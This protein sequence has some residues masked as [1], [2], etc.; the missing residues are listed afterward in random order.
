MGK[1]FPIER[2]PPSEVPYL[3][4][5][6]TGTGIGPIKAL[7]EAN[8]LQVRRK[9]VSQATAPILSAPKHVGLHCDRDGWQS[10][11]SMLCLLR[12]L[13]H[14]RRQRRGSSQDCTMAPS[15]QK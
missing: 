5:F 15:T 11:G 14:L 6:A 7:I 13:G 4:I 3:F 9:R 8:A 12:L 2:A 1:G 10:M